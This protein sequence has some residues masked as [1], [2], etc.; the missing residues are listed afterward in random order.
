MNKDEPP[1]TTPNQSR[2]SN[3]KNSLTKLINNLDVAIIT[4]KKEED[5]SN[6][7]YR[8]IYQAEPQKEEETSAVWKKGKDDKIYFLQNPYKLKP[9][10]KPG[11]IKLAA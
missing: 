11:E 3:P 8:P 2:D 5:Q 10:S 1:D 6:K 9:A 7:P 4:Q